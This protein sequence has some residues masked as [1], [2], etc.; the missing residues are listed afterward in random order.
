MAAAAEGE[1]GSNGKGN[2]SG[3]PSPRNGTPEEKVPPPAPEAV[4]A[5]VELIAELGVSRGVVQPGSTLASLR[6]N[7][8]DLTQ[9]VLMVEQKVNG[10]LPHDAITRQ[11]TVADVAA[12]MQAISLRQGGG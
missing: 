3:A 5:V 2:S 9:F 1:H 8:D 11:S 6:M 7:E 12:L 4:A 10:P